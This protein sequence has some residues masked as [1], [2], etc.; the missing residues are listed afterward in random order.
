MRAE[1]PTSKAAE[2]LRQMERQFQKLIAEAGSAGQYPDVVRLASVAEG[3]D[4]LANRLGSG[5]NERESASSSEESVR[6]S[7]KKRQRK[8]R[9]PKHARDYPRFFRSGDELMKVGWSKKKKKEYKHT[10]PRRLAVALTKAIVQAGGTESKVATADF[11]PIE[12]PKDHSEVPSYQTYIVLAWLVE[13]GIV[14]KHGRQGYT[15][16]RPESLSDQVEDQWSSLA[17]VPS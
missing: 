16:P 9:K 2:L 14:E 15:I 3:I 5:E 11:F 17:P 4:Q 8:P 7:S 12:D 6:A 13:A 1:D 10:A